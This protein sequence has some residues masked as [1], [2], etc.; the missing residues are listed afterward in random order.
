MSFE[1]AHEIVPKVYLGNR[2]F[3]WSIHLLKAL[4]IT[5]IVN[6]A[7]ELPNPFTD[8]IN[9]KYFAL[10]DSP[11]QPIDQHFKEAHQFIEDAIGSGGAVLIH[12]YA[13]ISRSATILT[14][15]LMKTYNMSPADALSH[16][17][18]IR[19]IVN[20]NKGFRTQLVK[21]YLNRNQEPKSVPLV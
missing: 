13:G 7:Q 3:A 16:I 12:C 15:Y 1:D 21:Y 14:S 20:P 10:H 4:G 19:P 9:Y 11:D 5:H 2:R 8:D 17:Q 6:C 18:R